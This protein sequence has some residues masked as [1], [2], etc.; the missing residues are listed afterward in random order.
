MHFQRPFQWTVGLVFLVALPAFAQEKSVAPKSEPMLD[1]L[2]A[3][4]IHLLPPAIAAE[5]NLKPEQ[6]AQIQRIEEEYRNKRREAILD[7]AGKV[8]T[9][10]DGVQDGGDF[11]SAPTLAICHEITG[12][13]LQSRRARIAYEKKMLAVLD[14]RQKDEFARLKNMGPLRPRRANPIEEAEPRFSVTKRAEALNL[15]DEQK[16]KLAE[17]QREMENR[18]RELLTPEQRQRLDSPRL[19]PAVGQ[20]TKEANPR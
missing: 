5:L 10:V 15:T 7:A 9:I 1:G 20:K 12:G 4:T 13:L 19:E 17:M 6:K 8:M 16:T 14:D 11:E 2:I 18:F 3:R